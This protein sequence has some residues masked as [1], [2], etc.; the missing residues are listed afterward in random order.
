MKKRIRK[1]KGLSKITNQ[2]VYSLNITLA[3][4]I[5]PRI[6][7][8]KELADSYPSQLNSIEEWH[9]ILDQIIW[10]LDK[11]IKDDLSS[12]TTENEINKYNNGMMLFAKYF[13]DLWI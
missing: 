1:K 12:K 2:E 6:I 11:H 9:Y 4:F 3:K 5:L 7:K 10:S 13:A 8:F